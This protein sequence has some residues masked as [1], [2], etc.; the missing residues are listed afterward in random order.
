MEGSSPPLCFTI[1]FTHFTPLHHFTTPFLFYL[2]LPSPTPFALFTDASVE[3]G[4]VALL[5]SA[6]RRVHGAY[7]AAKPAPPGDRRDCMARVR[8]SLC[9]RRV[10]NDLWRVRASPTIS[11]FVCVC[12]ARRRRNGNVNVAARACCICSLL[13]HLRMPRV[14][15]CAYGFLLFGA[16]AR[17][18]AGWRLRAAAWRAPTLR[19][20]RGFNMKILQRFL[21][22]LLY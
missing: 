10:K 11:S 18:C 9:G 2:P 22:Y 6:P 19:G 1:H 13:C 3:L 7:V 15:A 4:G 14:H 20:A 5:R 8:V 16:L 17:G 21:L 12:A